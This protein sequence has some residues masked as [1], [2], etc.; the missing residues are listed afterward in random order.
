MWSAEIRNQEV[1]VNQERLLILFAFESPH[2][3]EE[4]TSKFWIRAPGLPCPHPMSPVRPAR[5]QGPGCYRHPPARPRAQGPAQGRRLPRHPP[6]HLYPPDF[7]RFRAAR[8]AP[9]RAAAAPRSASSSAARP[10]S[11]PQ[12]QAEALGAPGLRKRCQ[13]Q[14]PE[15]A[16]H[17]AATPRP[18][19]ALAPSGSARTRDAHGPIPAGRALGMYTATLYTVFGETSVPGSP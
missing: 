16:R 8:K 15:R 12:T 14:A 7:G 9:R 3:T 1:G 4:F 6:A 5:S 10:R 18:P 13:P 19:V 2:F 17:A 11:A